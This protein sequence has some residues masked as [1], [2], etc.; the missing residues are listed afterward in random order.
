MNFEELLASRGLYPL[1]IDNK[2]SHV[3]LY[4]PLADSSLLADSSD[5]QKIYEVLGNSGHTDPDV[6]EIIHELTNTSFPN[7]RDGYVRGFEDFR[8]LSIL[9]NNICNFT[10]SY[11]YSAKGRS[12]E[13]LSYRQAEIA[14][15]TFLSTRS[16]H[17]GLLTITIY[18]GGEP[19]LSWDMVSPLID[20]IFSKAS[21]VG[22]RVSLTLITNGSVLPKGF[23]TQC[24][25]YNLDLVISYEILEE[26][27]NQQR[28]HYNL[29]TG[30]ILSLLDS[31]VIPAFNSVITPLNVERQTEMVNIVAERFKRVEYLSFEPVMDVVEDSEKEYFYKLFT[32]EFIT[33]QKH[34]ESLGIKL[35]TSV[36][37]NVDVSVDRYCP[38][39]MA[40]TADGSL[41]ICP[42]VS[43]SK[44]ANYERYVYGCITEEGM[45]KVDNEKLQSLL[46]V[47]VNSNPWCKLC[48]SKWNCG[49]GCMNNNIKNGYRQDEHYCA[50]VRRFVKYTIAKRL[51]EAYASM[52]EASI[53]QYVGDY[54]KIIG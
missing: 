13:K 15:D 23:I 45:L 50:F 28:K 14:V 53:K 26:V 30:N 5:L 48:F 9:P 6:A 39:E 44:D 42:C 24:R 32:R 38:G 12:S 10:C 34:A 8:N 49:G 17:Q 29:V 7:Q 43:S 31:R 16:S 19:L 47:N 27:Q 3:I 4:A 36:L 1:R 33:A 41:T 11:C 20:H 52:G 40:I 54:E 37:R 51:D 18:G 2:A 35:T 46:S 21:E 25:Q 22:R